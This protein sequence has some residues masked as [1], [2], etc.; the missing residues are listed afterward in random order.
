MGYIHAELDVICGTYQDKFVINHN[1]GE[2]LITSDPK[3]LCNTEGIE[4]IEITKPYTNT[5]VGGDS[6]Q[7]DNIS[8]INISQDLINTINNKSQQYDNLY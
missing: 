3:H 1:Y 8:Q 7:T 2:S 6:V 5:H 4:Y